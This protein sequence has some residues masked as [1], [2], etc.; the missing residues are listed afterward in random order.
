LQ[1]KCNKLLT[2]KIRYNIQGELRKCGILHGSE[3]EHY[4]T[5]LI[6]CHSSVDKIYA[7]MCYYVFIVLYMHILR[8]S[9]YAVQIQLPENQPIVAINLRERKT[10]QD[11]D[12]DKLRNPDSFQKSLA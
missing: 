6:L 4:S 8:S 1:N 12:N 3:A 5:R 9:C 7:E 10:R 2:V 11:T